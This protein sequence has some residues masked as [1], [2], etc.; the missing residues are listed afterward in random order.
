MENNL[1]VEI[2]NTCASS[3]ANHVFPAGKRKILNSDA[4]LLWH[5][6]SFQPDIDALV[7]SGDQFAQEWRETETTFWK[8]IG[9]SPNIATCGL[10]QAPAFGRL[11]HLLRITSLK[12]FDYSIKDMHRF[13]LT[14]VDVSG[15]QWSGTTSGKFRGAFRAKFCKK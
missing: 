9:L 2:V 1:D 5:G 4:V 8:R 6:S 11:L 15:G 13:G 10:S 3:C 7:Q 12:G 14:G